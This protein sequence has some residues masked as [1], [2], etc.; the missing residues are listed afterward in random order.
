VTWPSAAITTSL[1]RRT[2]ITVVERILTRV[3]S[4][5][6]LAARSAPCVLTEKRPPEAAV[7]EN[8]RF[9]M[10]SASIAQASVTALAPGPLFSRRQ[11]TPI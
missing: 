10:S 1:P 2:Q 3:P 6:S 9:D 5:Q 4:P 8:L 7:S 11:I